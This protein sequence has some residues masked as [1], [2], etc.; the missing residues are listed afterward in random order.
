M[1][2]WAIVAVVAVPLLACC[3]DDTEALP[4]SNIPP[5][6]GPQPE[7]GPDGR[8]PD[9][10]ADGPVGP[11][12]KLTILHTNDIHSHVNGFGPVQDYTPDTT[13]DDSTVGGMARLAAKIAAER[14][15]AGKNVLLLDAGDFHQGS[16]FDWLN[17]TKA[18][19]LTLFQNSGY[20]VSMEFDGEA[21][22]IA[23]DLE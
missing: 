22:S 15:A 7:V 2:A 20:N 3:S 10:T 11:E 5:D 8:I 4:D 1:R 13:D 14:T 19:M 12:Y 17:T 18:P 6:S 16:L 23:Y 9:G 21:Y